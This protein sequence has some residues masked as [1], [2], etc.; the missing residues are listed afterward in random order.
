M[1]FVTGM[2]VR[3]KKGHDKG[4]FYVVLSAADR[5]MYLCDAEKYTREQPKKKNPLHLAPT[6]TVLDLQSPD[7]DSVIRQTLRAFQ[8]RASFPKEVI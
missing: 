5:I 6:K 1:K 7:A 2:I 8:S 3:S 4:R